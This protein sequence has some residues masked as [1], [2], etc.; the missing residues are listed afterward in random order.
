[1]ILES[2][3]AGLF[4]GVFG[5]VVGLGGG[6]L[7]VPALTLL[8]GVPMSDAI[9]ASLVGVVA[10]AM[11]GTASFLK[12]GHTD[13]ALAIRAG[14]ITVLGALIGARLGVLVPERALQLGFALLIFIIVWGMFRGRHN[15]DHTSG[16]ASLWRALGLF[17]GAGLLAG[18]L[19]VGGGILNVPAI[20]LALKRTIIVAVATSTM[21][22]AF[23]GIAGASVYA[24]AGM[25]KWSLAAGC[26]TGAFVGGR[27]GAALAPRIP[28]K[29]LQQIF[30]FVIL[31]VG[32]EMAVRGFEL[33][34]W[35]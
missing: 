9:P 2:I 35:R 15:D 20:R 16:D 27:M 7:M 23:T 4:A 10:T 22:I 33:P 26:A 19:G 29:H 25:L 34:W 14:A 32:I 31:Y 6:I 5:A 30:V 18:M 13:T 24:S 3:V 11:G 17:L 28:R 1:V 21:I 8:F 12:K